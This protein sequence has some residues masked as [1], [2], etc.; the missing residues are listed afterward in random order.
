MN[1]SNLIHGYVYRYHATAVNTIG[2]SDASTE[3]LFAALPLP[4]KPA[5]VRRYSISTRSELT[6]EWDVEPDGMLPITGYLVEA[7]LT[8][9]N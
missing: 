7:D 8:M 4:D 5:P 1:V 6:I 2:E 3:F 9:N